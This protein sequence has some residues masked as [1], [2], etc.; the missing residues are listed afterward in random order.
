MKLR[1]FVREDSSETLSENILDLNQPLFDLFRCICVYFPLTIKT[2]KKP[3]LSDVII[4]FFFFFLP[5]LH[6][7]V[8]FEYNRVVLEPD[9]K[10]VA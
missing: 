9:T 1:D 8:H 4:N 7:K 3:T 5:L 10:T 2:E 6:S